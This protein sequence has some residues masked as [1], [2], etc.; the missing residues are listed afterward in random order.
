MGKSQYDSLTTS[1][2]LAFHRRAGT[3]AFTHT[4]AI[5][6]GETEAKVHEL[7]DPAKKNQAGIVVRESRDSE[8]SPDSRAIAVLF[9]V[10]GSMNRTPRTFI[11]KLPSLMSLLIRKGILDSPQILFAAIGDHTADK[12][13]LQIGQFESG[14]EMDAA[15]T[16]AYLEGGGGWP[17]PEESYEL[18]MYFLS[19]YAEMDCLTK[20]NKKGI[21]FIIG[22]ERPHSKV[23]AD[24]VER[25][26]G[27]RPE[28]D[29]P[30]TEVLASLR[31]KFDVF[32]IFPGGTLHEHD[33][34]VLTPLK[35][36]FGDNFI[37]LERADDIA[38]LIAAT[39]AVHEGAA[40]TDLQ[41]QLVE[42]G[43]DNDSAHR[44]VSS[45]MGYAATV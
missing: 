33:E 29:L 16:H 37:R 44:A 25:I 21:C 17:L 3:D 35:A 10:T 42:S 6:Q 28:S 34:K 40:V 11:E 14:N 32:W 31:E 5:S 41:K 15:L 45:V 36:M 12:V 18:G 39:I 24:V 20:R 30:T 8:S 43:A 38:E 13:P 26:V 2:Y 23:S 9:D 27:E 22:D 19:R 1:S 4:A 7:L